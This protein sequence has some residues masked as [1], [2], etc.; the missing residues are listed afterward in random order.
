MKM[1]IGGRE[2]E[3]VEGDITD[4][5][6]D[7]IVNAA[8]SSL[9]LG[10]GVAGAISRRGGPTIQT[11]CNRIGGT[12]VG[13]AVITGAG[14]LPA[15][16]VIHAV[17][18]RWGEGNEAE[19]LLNAIVNSLKLADKHKL[20]SIAFPSISTGI[21]RFPLEPAARIMLGSAAK[22][23]EGATGI[24]RVIFCLY[25]QHAFDVFAQILKEKGDRVQGA[26][27]VPCPLNPA[28]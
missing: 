2:L 9:W 8:N 10:G 26:G 28:P 7:A 22:Y 19:K 13:G 20:R 6:V 12:F 23:L 11:E 21:F 24:E 17:G 3:L 14:N 4:L 5:S 25:G 16:H 27:H 1:K 15:K 18:P